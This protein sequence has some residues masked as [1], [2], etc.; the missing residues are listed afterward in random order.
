M[1]RDEYELIRF[2]GNNIFPLEGSRRYLNIIKKWKKSGWIFDQRLTETGKKV[3]YS[4]HRW[5]E[6]VNQI[7]QVVWLTDRYGSIPQRKVTPT[8]GYLYRTDDSYSPTKYLLVTKG[9]LRGEKGAAIRFTE[10]EVAYIRVV[11]DFDK[12]WRHYNYIGYK[13]TGI[14]H[15]LHALSSNTCEFKANLL[16]YHISKITEFNCQKTTC[17]CWYVRDKVF[18]ERQKISSFACLSNKSMPLVE[19]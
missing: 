12:I 11:N 17:F 8:I 1:R 16:E 13:R 10:N 15:Y 7:V 4:I 6:R 19:L 3:L 14:S 18:C 2:Y 5:R 9:Y